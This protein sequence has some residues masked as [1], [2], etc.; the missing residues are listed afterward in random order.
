VKRPRIEHGADCFCVDCYMERKIA[1][2]VATEKER[3]AK[4]ADRAHEEC[5]YDTFA[6]LAAAIRAGGEKP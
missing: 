2:A 6:A 1:E 4:L 3:I 5:I